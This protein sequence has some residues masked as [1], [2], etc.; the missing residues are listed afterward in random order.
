MSN[1]NSNRRLLA[2]T[3]RI[4]GAALL[5]I[6]VLAGQ[7]WLHSGA[8]ASASV[9]AVSHSVQPAGAESKAAA[10]AVRLLTGPR[11]RAALD[12]LPAD[13]AAVMGYRPVVVDGYPIN[14][15]GDCSSPIPLPG[16]FEILCK[17]HD[18]G[19][20]LL[21][22]ADH[23]GTPLGPW[24]RES[25]DALLISRMHAACAD[26]LCSA[27]ADLSRI[28]LAANTWRQSGG[29]PVAGESAMTITATV[30]NR[31]VGGPA[32]SGQAR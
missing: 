7:L 8:G 28:G 5:G 17:S 14:P 15:S 18:F 1:N 26:P 22:Y 16:Q 9:P 11:H 3:I 20:D 12:A 24:A 29:P 2:M 21:R 30:L 31:A 23:A 27:A 6:A 4:I 19:Y 13:F 25:L 32:D 10:T